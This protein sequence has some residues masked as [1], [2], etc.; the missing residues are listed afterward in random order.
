ME[1][2]RFRKFFAFSLFLALTLFLLYILWPYFSAFFG[3]IILFFLFRPLHKFFVKKFKF[4]KP[5]SALGVIFLVL[6]LIVVPMFFVLN[7]SFLQI[8][9]INFR[10][11][12]FGNF[13]D[14]LNERFGISFFSFL[15]EFKSYTRGFF[16]DILTQI[17]HMVILLVI[18]FFVL[19]YLLISEETIDEKMEDIIP[20]TKKH[21]QRLIKEFKMITYSTLIVNFLI[22]LLQGA[23]LGVGFYLI[24]VPNVIIAGFLGAVFSF[25][26]ALGAGLVW[27]AVALYYLINLDYGVALFVFILGIFVSTIDN[28]VRPGL[29]KKIGKV[30]PIITLVGIF[31]GLPLFGLIG[32]VIGPLLLSYFLLMLRM[33]QEEYFN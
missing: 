17:P 12:D 27:G 24:G 13:S 14:N 21:S 23:L 22:A 5:L 25:V 29:Q 20:F 30:H 33:I 1:K 15:D 32:L 16:I 9:Q 10:E 8:Q 31:V 6:I 11:M 26:P 2:E 18:T 28:F 19:Y 7:L 4:P 3:A